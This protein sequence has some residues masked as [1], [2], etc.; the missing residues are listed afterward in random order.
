MKVVEF[1]YTKDNGKVSDRTIVELIQ[2]TNHVEGI[3]VSELDHDTYADF[4][5][6]LNQLEREINT[7]RME[8]YSKF[9]LSKSYRRFKPN[10]MT[11]ITHEYM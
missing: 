4:V 6:E 9:D 7:K 1:T 10:Q 3:D 8:L 11:N 5:R 2:P